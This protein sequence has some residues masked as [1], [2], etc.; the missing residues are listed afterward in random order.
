MTATRRAFLRLVSIAPLAFSGAA[1][2]GTAVIGRLIREAPSG[3]VQPRIEFI[4]RA[5]LGV[6]YQA[7]T[8][9][10]GPWQAE[11]LVMREDAFDCVTYCETVLAAALSRNVEEFPSMLRRIRYAH[12]EVRWSDR[13]HYFADW[14][15]RNADKGIC[16][17][18]AI[19]PAEQITKTVHGVLGPRP[20]SFVASTS[21]ALIANAQKLRAG[22]IVGFVSRQTHLDFFH[23]GFIAF[24]RNGRLLLRHASQS[25]GRV[26]DEDM[27][28][29]LAANGVRYV[30]V[31]RARDSQPGEG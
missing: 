15:A 8:L 29:F 19:S 3:A 1:G 23:V 12:D 18:L 7:D 26:L 20:E 2:A 28:S 17:A 14:I 10:G 25:H 30:S 4:S 13:N 6:R 16:F 31:L 9:I 21:A 24:A 11:R 5:L 27:R 22:D